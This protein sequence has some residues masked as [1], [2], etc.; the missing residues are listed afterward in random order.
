M[1]IPILMFCLAFRVSMDYEVFLL[2]RIKEVRDRHGDNAA[3]VAMGLAKTG[4]IVTAAV[5]LLASV[6]IAVAT[7]GVTLIKLFGIGLALAVVID[8]TLVR[9]GL[10]P[11]VMRLASEANGRQP[12]GRHRKEYG[13]R[14][15]GQ[16]RKR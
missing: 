12:D 10:V 6:L 14:K 15:T 13:R 2:S 5:A 7:S 3:A 16:H 8:T 9:I 11:A 1:A 4:R